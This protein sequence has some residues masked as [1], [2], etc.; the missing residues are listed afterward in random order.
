MDYIEKKISKS[1]ITDDDI[2][3]AYL[4]LKTDAYYDRVNLFIRAK[5]AEFEEEYINRGNGSKFNNLKRTIKDLINESKDKKEFL[6]WLEEIN[7]RIIP[8]TIKNGVADLF[9]EKN[10]ITNLREGMDY[11]V[12]KFNYYI[13][14]PIPLQ[15]L[16]VLWVENIGIYLDSKLDKSCLGYRIQGNSLRN[17]NI[18]SHRLF[19][20]YVTQYNSWRDNAIKRATTLLDEG[21]NILLGAIDIKECFYHLHVNFT[22]I[23]EKI[24]EENDLKDVLF[25][26]RLNSILGEIYTSYQERIVSNIKIT[27]G[28]DVTSTKCGIPI[29]LPSSGVIANHI[30]SDIDNLIK[31]E[32][33]P[34]YYGRYVDD[35]LFVIQNPDEKIIKTSLENNNPKKFLLQRYFKKIIKKHGKEY[36]FINHPELTINPDKI[37]LHYYDHEHSHAGLYEF[38]RELEKQASEFRFLPLEDEDL[39]ISNCAYDIH[40]KGSVNKLRSVIGISENDTELSKFFSKKII[41]FRLT[42]TKISEDQIKDIFRFYKGRNIFDFCRIWE[43]VFILFLIN[44][45]FMDLERFL[46][47]I[48]KVISKL[49]FNKEG[50]KN[51]SKDLI[52]KTKSDL[53]YYLSIALCTSLSL[54]GEGDL[55]KNK[56]ALG[57]IVNHLIDENYYYLIKI[58][59]NSNMLRQEVVSWPLIN[60]SDYRGNFI[61]FNFDSFK[62]TDFKLNNQKIKYS[63]CFIYFDDFQVYRILG[64]IIK[65]KN[66]D[67]NNEIILKEP[68]SIINPINEFKNEYIV[69]FSRDNESIS[70]L[71]F[72]YSD[73]EEKSESSEIITKQL[74]IEFGQSSKSD[75]SLEN[76]KQI[77]V[78]LA[79]MKILEE[80]YLCSFHPRK[81]PKI[82]YE[83]Q[84]ILYKLL[85]YSL[86]NPKCDLLVFPE[87]SIPYSWLPFMIDQSRNKQIG[88]IFGMEHWVVGRY[89]LNLVVTILPFKNNLGY[90]NC[91]ISMRLKNHYS[92]KEEYMLE[93][94]NLHKP[95]WIPLY[96]LF[97]WRNLVF[98][99]YNCYELS[100]IKHR[101]IFRSLIDL[102]I[103]VEWN[104]DTNYYSNI[105]ESTVRDIHCYMIQSNTS[106]YGDSRVSCPKK[107]EEMDI[108]KIKGGENDL[109]IK[110]ILD[111]EKLRMFQSHKF[112]PKDKSFK[113]TPAGYD[114]ELARKR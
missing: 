56:G 36:A 99:V 28:I 105:V 31:S 107:T 49:V 92:P 51:L 35:I 76:K 4:K 6:N 2:E 98:T 32:Y 66:Q 24:K 58:I 73:V 81:K 30:L 88:L 109:I 50:M 113:P 39:Q 93:K 34:V 14:I 55:E 108:L 94:L 84:A 75:F 80:D 60:Y 85:N 10:I 7:Y 8:K 71:S 53:K 100:D 15:I 83:R 42:S 48:N 20:F 12:E 38:K 46:N 63:P 25:F 52:K 5:I 78:G 112:D 91:V 33:S 54:I 110:G 26:D 77:C 74:K 86:E 1:V 111:I 57:R 21:E 106:Q 45:N 22:E 69:K 95:Q 59:R 82:N 96:E 40:Y 11:S 89:A 37:I 104:Q 114:H 23:F 61:K 70:N 29:G 65:L 9:D 68:L 79:N 27:H 102:L 44:D 90:K 64:Q 19:K 16:S 43:K 3:I 101:S 18:T 62:S 97:K 13:D 41:E 72:D 87:V 47:E 17:A 67:E 103:A